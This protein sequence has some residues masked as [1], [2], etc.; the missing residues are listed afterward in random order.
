[1]V[2]TIIETIE[3]LE[4]LTLSETTCNKDYKGKRFTVY[5][6]ASS[7]PR[8]KDVV[9][10][11]PGCDCRFMYGFHLAVEMKRGY[12]VVRDEKYAD[13]AL[14]IKSN[15]H[16]MASEEVA[17]PIVVSVADQHR[18]G[19]CA[20]H[21]DARDFHNGAT[22]IIGAR[23]RLQDLANEYGFMEQEDGNVAAMLM[24]LPYPCAQDAIQR[25]ISAEKKRK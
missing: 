22:I 2:E 8:Y 1:M 12:L 24:V 11:V 6:D 3:K 18:M 17:R 23:S 13:K 7:F 21:D 4:N 19:H 14:F 15:D 10:H 25:K 5:K 9:V 16:T 20:R